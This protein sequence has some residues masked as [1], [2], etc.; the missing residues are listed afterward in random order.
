MPLP[1][2]LR[3][4]GTGE[5]GAVG[6]TFWADPYHTQLYGAERPMRYPNTFTPHASGTYLAVP[7]LLG[8]DS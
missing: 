5:T 6:S 1:R 8:R 4:H 7:S 2:G 3:G